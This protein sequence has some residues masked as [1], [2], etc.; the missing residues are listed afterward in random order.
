MNDVVA[1]AVNGPGS[2]SAWRQRNKE[3]LLNDLVV[4]GPATQRQLA[5]RT[6]LSTA[7]ISNLVK[8]LQSENCITTYP[9]V[10]SN[11]RAK[12]VSLSN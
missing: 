8:V 4:N 9:T 11:R 12:L 10:S 7:T 6:G 5:Q 1:A 3:L 2:P